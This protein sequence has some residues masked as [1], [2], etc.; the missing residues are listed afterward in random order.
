M[1]ITL[2]VG[3]NDSASSNENEM[4][5]VDQLK[6]ERF[7]QR[8]TQIVATL[9]EEDRASGSSRRHDDEKRTEE[10]KSNICL[11]EA[12][13]KLRNKSVPEL[14]GSNNISLIALREFILL[15]FIFFVLGRKVTKSCFSPTHSRQLLTVYSESQKSSKVHLKTCYICCSMYIHTYMKGM[16]P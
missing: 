6:L 14:K 9:I 4:T 10:Q 15:Q 13:V 5:S 3:P 11:S 1:D 7:L 8:T 2:F 12:F 16:C